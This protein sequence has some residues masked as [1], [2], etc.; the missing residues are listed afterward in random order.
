MG[1]NN[2]GAVIAMIAIVLALGVGIVEA[3]EV[4]AITDIASTWI[5]V[6]LVLAGLVLGLANIKNAESVPF[7]VATLILAGGFAVLA[8]IPYVGEPLQIVFGRLT[9]VF[10]PAALMVA[11]VTAFKKIIN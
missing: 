10:V 1:K 7:M 6:I 3:T 8:V 11:L 4:F 9:A 2:F 5:T